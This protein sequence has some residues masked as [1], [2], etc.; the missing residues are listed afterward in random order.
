MFIQSVCQVENRRRYHILTLTSCPV[1][2]CRPV[3]IDI[4]LKS[5]LASVN[6]VRQARNQQGTPIFCHL[7][8]LAHV[9]LNG[10]TNGRTTVSRFETIPNVSNRC[11]GPSSYVRREVGLDDPRSCDLCKRACLTP[12]FVILCTESIEYIRKGHYI[13]CYETAG[14]VHMTEC[15]PAR[16]DELKN[17]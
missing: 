17:P 11:R 6:Q 10:E 16:V 8:E 12:Y 14:R 3:F 5:R 4:G 1:G 9:R 15:A 7:D 13:A 2:T